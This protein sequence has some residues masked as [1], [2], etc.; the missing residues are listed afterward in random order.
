VSLLQSYGVDINGTV[1]VE[2]VDCS[3][4]LLAATSMEVDNELGLLRTCE[5]DNTEM[6]GFLLRAGADI[7]TCRP[8]LRSLHQQFHHCIDED[9]LRWL[10]D[11][12]LDLTG[13]SICGI[14]VRR[15]PLGGSLGVLK[16]LV[17]R[18][19][20]IFSPGEP[21]KD[22][23]KFTDLHPLSLFI[24]LK[25]GQEFI[26]EV[27]ETGIDVNGTGRDVETNTPLRAAVKMKDLRLVKELVSRGALINDVECRSKYTPLQLACGPSTSFIYRPVNFDMAKYLLERG[28][29]PNATSGSVHETPLRLA[30]LSRDSDIQLIEL[31]LEYGADVNQMA[32]GSIYDQTR[33]ILHAALTE[34]HGLGAHKQRVVEMLIGRGANV[35]ARGSSDGV[36]GP[37]ALEMTCIHNGPDCVDFVRLLLDRGAELT[38]PT[39]Y[40]KENALY[41]ACKNQNMDLIKLLLNQGMD[42]NQ[43]NWGSLPLAVT[44]SNGDLVV[45]VLLL[46]AGAKVSIGDEYTAPLIATA[47]NGRLDMVALLLNFETREE[48]HKYA[49]DKAR[50]ENHFGIMLYIDRMLRTRWS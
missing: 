28:A 40:Y 11:N 50:E 18:N 41:A 49:I 29:D 45:A 16:S 32:W 39:D 9:Q 36:S 13:E 46:A 22:Y 2:K 30:L 8:V 27:L 4:L 6:L 31:L 21:T 34:A 43:G 37:S 44:A 47:K 3:I 19:V 5:S 7:D 38:P 25:P 48:V 1:R 33:F 14:M 42:P 35:N 15:L 24:S 10:I 17:R 20:P 26:S 12:G 23:R